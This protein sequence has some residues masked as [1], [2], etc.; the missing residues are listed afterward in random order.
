M[1]LALGQVALTNCRLGVGRLDAFRLDAV[2]APPPVPHDPSPA[3]GFAGGP[4]AVAWQAESSDRFD[5]FF[6]TSPS[7]PLVSSNQSGQTW[8]LP[9]LTAGVTYYWRVVAK[10]TF[11]TTSSPVWTIAATAPVAATIVSPANGATEIS[12]TPT[13]T[14]IGPP[15]EPGATY[16]VLFN[17]AAGTAPQEFPGLTTTSY[18]IGPLANGAGYL[19]RVATVTNAGYTLSPVWSF[20]TWVVLAPVYLAPADGATA[21]SVRPT[22]SWAAVPHATSYDVYFDRVSP[23]SYITTTPALSWTPPADLGADTTYVWRIVARTIGGQGVIGAIWSFTTTDPTKP[24]IRIDGAAPSMRIAGLTIHDLLNDQP[25]TCTFTVD[26]TPPH[27]GQ[28]IQIGLGTITT[29]D[30]VFAGTIDQVDAIYE[31]VPANRAWRVTGIDWWRRFNR[32][33][34]LRVYPEQ[35]ATA[36][37]LDLIA[38]YAPGFTAAHVVD[39]LPIVSGGIDFTQEDLGACLTRLMQRVGGYWYVDYGQ[40][41]H[42]YLTE[43][44]DAPDPLVVGSPTLQNDPSVTQRTDLSQTRTRVLVTGGGSQTTTDIAAGSTAIPLEDATWFRPDG[45]GVAL[46]GTQRIPHTGVVISAGGT[47]VRGMDAPSGGAGTPSAALTA[48]V[49]GVLGATGYRVSFKAT[50]GETIPGPASNTVTGVPFAAPTSNPGVT[51][52]PG[53]GHLSGSYWYAVSYV[54]PR[55]ETTLG[56]A[57]FFSATAHPTPSAPTVTLAA[58][59]G[60]LVGAY[61][62]RVAFVTALGETLPSATGSRTAAAVSAPGALSPNSAGLGPLIGAYT[63]RVTF[64]TALGETLGGTVASRTAAALTAPSAPTVDTSQA[65]HRNGPLKGAYQWKVSFVS[66]YGETLG[67]ATGVAT[68]AAVTA[69]PP[70]LT[71]DG[72]GNKIDI[73]V[74]WFSSQWGESEW[75]AVTTDT[76]HGNP[77]VITPASFPSD[78]TGWIAFSSGSYTSASPPATTFRMPDVYI[79]SAAGN[80][81]AGPG[82]V[83]TGAAATMGRKAGLGI[84]TGPSGTTARRLYRTKAGGSEYFLVAEVRDNTT[85]TY[86]DAIPDSALIVP[87]PAQNLN[88]ETF[89]LSLIPTGPP[90][91]VARRVYRTKGGGADYFRLVELPDN[92]TT[93][94]TDTVAD[95]ALTAS[96]PPLVA[97]AGGERHSVTLPI[98]PA[99]TL[100]R[101]VYRTKAGGTTEI[102]LVE[103]QDNSTT[104]YTDETPDSGLAGKGPELVSTAGGV[105]ASVSVPTG[106]TGTTGRTVYRTTAGGSEYFLVAR[107]HGNDGATVIDKKDDEALGVAAP[108]VNDAG[109]SIVAVSNIAIGPAS[110]VARRLYR[111]DVTGLYRFVTEIK[112][113]TTTTFTD[114]REDKQLGDVAP[115][116]STIGALPGATTLL[117]E[118]PAA[119]LAAGGWFESGSQIVRYTGLSGN[120]LTGI[121]A[122]GSGSLVA[123][124][125]AGDEVVASSML[126]G[127]TVSVA[128]ARG[129]QVSVL[130]TI[131]DGPAQTALAALEGGGSTGIYE[132]TL[133][134]ARLGWREAAAHGAADL[135]R[136]SKP[137][138]T[139]RYASR[140]RKTATGKTIHVDLVS[141]AFTGD[142][143]I[144]SVTIDQIGASKG[145]YP[146]YT[147]EASSVRWTFE[148]ILRQVLLTP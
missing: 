21:V 133:S 91:T 2:L 48:G 99:G 86:T 59:L 135:T 78:A 32:Y 116:V 52:V 124:L 138:V 57:T 60:P 44:T 49:G 90:G 114:D 74:A 131:N 83:A 56:P 67:T 36:I 58:G 137:V 109:G 108:T 102:L 19:W 104:T 40:D 28:V 79:G 92:S 134:D 80:L 115:T 18:P 3:H 130:E 64:V 76:N 121:P 29:A 94:Y 63:Y 75:S 125:K 65:S 128:I 68:I 30:L 148:D 141:L 39:G 147:V 117:V 50:A 66:A 85:T 101:R 41:V 24:I 113:N 87:A 126:T 69:S 140:D 45:T 122:S 33:K 95:T 17:N 20:T 1:S 46:T 123:P 25:N 7:P 107:I 119:F 6:G 129:D 15:L 43:P 106:P 14:W 142:F 4:Y 118:S 120:A 98:G 72:T 37:V 27:V 103:V 34:V 61:T 10:N 82:T 112:D 71:G 38:T 93:S 47:I 9:P 42:A 35:S 145:L 110:I 16:T 26:T 5:V 51:A 88:G 100:A 136:F 55:G 54:T 31:G 81:G 105:D 73:R 146:R 84:P 62:Y 89:S 11:G 53:L 12:N 111:R 96:G 22:L 127:A 70:V 97:T 8:L 139:M 143:I 13:L 77:V 144:Q 132:H 23:P